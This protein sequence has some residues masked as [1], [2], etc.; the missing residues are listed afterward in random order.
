MGI[1]THILDTATGTPASEVLLSLARWQNEDWELLQAAATDADGRCKQLL[2][3]DDRFV[4]G[5]YRVRF[6]TAAYYEA[7]KLEGLYP[8]VDV[9]FEVRPE[10]AHYHIALLLT[11]NG[12]TTYRGS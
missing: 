12:Y 10:Q 11:A 6:D 2:P 4:P 1:S 9:V 5:M 8:Y 3:D 7:N